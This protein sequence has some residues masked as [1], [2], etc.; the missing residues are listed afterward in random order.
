MHSGDQQSL[1]APEG[2]SLATELRRRASGYHKPSRE[3]AEI[4]KEKLQGTCMWISF[5][6][7]R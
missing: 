2:E 5:G 7:C 1:V 6:E 3:E 4:G